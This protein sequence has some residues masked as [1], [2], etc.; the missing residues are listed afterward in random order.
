MWFLSARD[1]LSPHPLVGCARS[2]DALRLRAYATFA[3]IHRTGVREL[4][5]WNRVRKNRSLYPKSIWKI[6][7]SDERK[8][9]TVG[10]EGA[11]RSSCSGFGVGAMNEW[12]SFNVE[13]LCESDMY[14]PSSQTLSYIRL[15]IRT[16]SSTTVGAPSLARFLPLPRCLLFLWATRSS[17]V[18]PETRLSSV[19]R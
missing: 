5:W 9:G 4:R 7:A 16:P 12:V 19:V 14:S 18:E 17:R 1:R 3:V 8:S 10:Y 13:S 11:S 6:R 2:P 15:H